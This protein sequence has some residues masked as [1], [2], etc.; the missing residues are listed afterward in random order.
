MAPL[1]VPSQAGVVSAD[2]DTLTEALRLF[3]AEPEAARAAGK[4]ARHFA[5]QHFG[6]ER[7]LRDWD[8]VIEEA[9]G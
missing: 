6:L 9:C 1:V 3:V 4:S 2:V 8:R 5:L 7:F